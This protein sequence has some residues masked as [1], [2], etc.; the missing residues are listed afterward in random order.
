MEVEGGSL[1]RNPDDFRAP[2][3]DMPVKELSIMGNT[4][5]W[6]RRP[7]LYVNTMCMAERTSTKGSW[8]ASSSG[9]SLSWCESPEHPRP[10]LFTLLPSKVQRRLALPWTSPHLVRA[11]GCRRSA[12]IYACATRWAG[13]KKRFHSKIAVVHAMKTP[14]CYIDSVRARSHALSSSPFIPS[15]EYSH[16]TTR[17]HG[18]LR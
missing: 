17:S 8:S 1:G 12:A 11:F 2:H 10:P 7:E 13:P 6:C 9:E 3:G 18:C 15:R 14:K 5:C 16:G 4:N